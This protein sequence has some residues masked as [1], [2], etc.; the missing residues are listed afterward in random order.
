MNFFDKKSKKKKKIQNS[1]KKYTGFKK[2]SKKAAK[3]NYV[4]N[5]LFP[6]KKEDL[7]T[8][9][10]SGVLSDV[11]ETLKEMT[12]KQDEFRD[13]IKS[14]MEIMNKKLDDLIK[15][16]SKK[17]KKETLVVDVK[18]IP[19][20]LFKWRNMTT[21][22]GSLLKTLADFKEKKKGR[23]CGRSHALTTMADYSGSSSFFCF[24]FVVGTK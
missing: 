24:V 22:C 5:K 23:R 9:E 18:Q 6:S 10:V 14:Q 17:G 11:F 3:V 20:L 19:K 2:G 1:K 16:G 7:P 15:N 21:E 8:A 4:L 12:T 13:E